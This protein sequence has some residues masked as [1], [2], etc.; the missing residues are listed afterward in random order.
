MEKMAS[1][2]PVAA[3]PPTTRGNK[4]KRRGLWTYDIIKEVIKKMMN[5]LPV[6]LLDFNQVTVNAVTTNMFLFRFVGFRLWNL[7][8]FDYLLTFFSICHVWL[9]PNKRLMGSFVCEDLYI[10]ERVSYVRW[11]IKYVIASENY[12]YS[13]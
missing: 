3:S 13:S 10:K 9:Y 5:L 11:S 7:W 12:K 1:T 4:P 8:K 6:E 2:D